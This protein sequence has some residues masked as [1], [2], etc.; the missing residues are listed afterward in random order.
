MPLPLLNVPVPTLTTILADDPFPTSC[1]RKLCPNTSKPLLFCLQNSHSPAFIGN[2]L[3]PRGCRIHN[4]GVGSSNRRL[5]SIWLPDKLE[6]PF[7]TFR[8]L[9]AGW[10][11]ILDGWQ[12]CM[13]GHGYIHRL[14]WASDDRQTIKG[15]KILQWLLR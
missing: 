1:C 10:L 7:M 14:D 9:P 15:S 4:S 5:Q 6:G 8:V 12:G 13:A 3:A 11:A 2:I